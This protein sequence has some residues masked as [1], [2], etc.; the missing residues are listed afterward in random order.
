M[1]FNSTEFICAFLPITFVIYFFLLGQNQHFAGRAW[2]ACASLFFYAY[3]NFWY[4]FLIL[5]SIGGNYLIAGL[6]SR[7]SSRFWLIVGIVGNLGLLG[8]Y[9]YANFFLDQ[10]NALAGSSYVIQGLVLPIGISFFTFQ[11]IAYLVDLY[12]GKAKQSDFVNYALFVSFFPQLIAGPIVHHRE[13]M[14]QLERPVALSR[15]Q[16][17]LAIGLTI[18]A[19]GL[20]KK[21]MI[22]DSFALAA[23]PMFDNAAAGVEISFFEAWGGALAYTFQLYFDFSGYSDMAI[24]LGRMA[25]IRLPA[26]FDSPYKATSIVDFW[27]RWH[28]TLSRF[29]RDY[30]YGPLGG[31][32]RGPVRRYANLMI[33]MLLGGLWHGAGW[34]FVIWGGLHGAYLMINHGWARLVEVQK[35]RALST[36]QGL[37]LTLGAV[38]FAWVVF[39][40]T[41][42]D[43]A[44]AVWAGMIGLN[45][46][47]LPNQIVE[48]LMRLSG[49]AF[50]Q[51]LIHLPTFGPSDPLPF[52]LNWIG[53]VFCLPV[54]LLLPNSLEIMRALEARIEGTTVDTAWFARVWQ[55]GIA[56]VATGIIFFVV[57]S[58]INS[59]A[60]TEFLYYQF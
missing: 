42:V 54:C 2:L 47:E 20:F 56:P 22:A 46:I 26:N 33:V 12:Q 19:I 59:A 43:A 41:S 24:G 51:L 21:V 58:R 15:L 31:N 11:Q 7:S 34:N 17:N 14:P 38:V 52:Y 40:A 32:R 6:L 5:I 35:V 39:R 16:E 36:G 53:I 45:G 10:F 8:Y 3:W 25:G 23:T 9:K 29:L 49:G 48:L 27:R 1:L 37:V 57:I 28:I 44:L 13:I 60:E 18:F 50:D 55:N 4:V 30:L